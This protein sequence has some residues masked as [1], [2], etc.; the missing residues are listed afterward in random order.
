MSGAVTVQGA[1]RQNPN[2]FLKQV[3]TLRSKVLCSKTSEN[4][5]HRAAS[6]CEAEL[7]S[8]LQRGKKMNVV[9]ATCIIESLGLAWQRLKGLAK[10]LSPNNVSCTQVLACLDGYMNIALEQTEEY[11][12]GQVGYMNNGCS[13]NSNANFL[14]ATFYTCGSASNSS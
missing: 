3:K 11:V 14:K 5:D 4:A 10:K 13:A 6:G 2:D 12:N 7:R 1:R 8:G 9:L